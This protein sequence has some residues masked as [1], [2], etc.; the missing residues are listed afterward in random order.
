MQKARHGVHACDLILEREHK[1]AAPKSSLHGQADPAKKV[2]SLKA[3]RESSNPDMCKQG[4]LMC[5]YHT[6]THK[7]HTTH[8]V[9]IYKKYTKF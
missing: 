6:Q 4:S 1:Q 5:I 7:H 9:V 2:S 8:M 3:V